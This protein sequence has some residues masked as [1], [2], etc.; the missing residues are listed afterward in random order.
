MIQNCIKTLTIVALILT[1]SSC[2]KDTTSNSFSVVGK[3]YFNDI[4]AWTTPNGSTS[5]VKDT[6]HYAGTGSYQEFT[7]TGKAYEKVFDFSSSTFNYD[8]A[9]YTI[10]GQNIT[11]IKGNNVGDTSVSEILNPATNSF[12]SHLIQTKVSGYK[13]IETWLYLTK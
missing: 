6:A 12:T 3:W 7:A 13:Q 9:D 1:I 2:K 5:I 11:V 4:I 10:N 8:T